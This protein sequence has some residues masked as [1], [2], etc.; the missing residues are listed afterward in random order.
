MYIVFCMTNYNSGFYF[1]GAYTSYEKAV[2]R[3]KWCKR[4]TI[5]EENDSWYIV[6]IDRNPNIKADITDGTHLYDLMEK[7]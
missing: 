3:L 7:E 1:A 5:D 2:R 6:N 4:H